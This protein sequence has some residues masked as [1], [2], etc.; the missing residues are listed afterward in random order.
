MGPPYGWLNI[1]GGFATGA[2]GLITAYIVGQQ[3]VWYILGEDTK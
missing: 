3:D 1:S 2:D